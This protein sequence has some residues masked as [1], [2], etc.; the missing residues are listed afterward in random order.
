[1]PGVYLN[2]ILLSF[3]LVGFILAWIAVFSLSNQSEFV[4]WL[5][6]VHWIS[7]KLFKKH[8]RK[9]DKII[10]YSCFG[11]SISC[12]VVISVGLGG[13]FATILLHLWNSP[14]GRIFGY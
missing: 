7:R 2:V 14:F 8:L 12:L 3:V 9:L 13:W 11:V 1:M 4:R 6:P 5:S 10:A